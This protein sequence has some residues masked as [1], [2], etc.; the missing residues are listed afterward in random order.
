MLEQ[1]EAMCQENVPF[2]TEREKRAR[3]G[4]MVVAAMQRGTCLAGRP[5]WCCGG[6]GRWRRFCGG[7]AKRVS[8][9]GIP[10]LARQ[11]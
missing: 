8:G 5:A 10:G 2:Q 9:A 6:G 4:N 3:V 7:Q 1:L 11:H